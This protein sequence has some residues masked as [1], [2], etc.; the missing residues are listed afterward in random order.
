MKQTKKETKKERNKERNKERKKENKKTRKIEYLK[1][2]EE[3]VHIPT[4]KLSVQ[5]KDE[6]FLQNRR[7]DT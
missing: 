7:S 1:T 3:M 6:F 4:L 5:A 2:L